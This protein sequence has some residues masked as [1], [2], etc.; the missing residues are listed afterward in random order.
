MSMQL[1]IIFHFISDWILQP[2]A[3]A[4][5]KTTSLKWML[6]HLAVIHV[7]FSIFALIEGYSQWLVVINTAAH[8]IID[9]AAWS[10]FAKARGPFDE[11]YLKVNK[12]AEDYWFYF[13]IAVDQIFHLS[14]LIWLFK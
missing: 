2:R 9:K 11:E 6:K 8:G 5:R 12:Y 10:L 14:L 4:K 3:V 1:I 7:A 13:T